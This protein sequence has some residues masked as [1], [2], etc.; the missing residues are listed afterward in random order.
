M[1]HGNWCPSHVTSPLYHLHT[2]VTKATNSSGSKGTSSVVLVIHPL[3]SCMPRNAKNTRGTRI[4]YILFLCPL[5]RPFNSRVAQ[6]VQVGPETSRWRLTLNWSRWFS[7]PCITRRTLYYIRS[8]PWLCFLLP[9]NNCL[10]FLT[11]GAE[12]PWPLFCCLMRYREDFSQAG[13]WLLGVTQDIDEAV[14]F[15]YQVN[16]MCWSP[17]DEV[18]SLKPQSV[19]T[20]GVNQNL[21]VRYST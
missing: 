6:L 19:W 7:G 18:I 3:C 9:A 14:K 17:S 1:N 16:Y 5:T 12:I 20:A 15:L 8:R 11:G 13:R 10:W 21:K 4:R 2:S